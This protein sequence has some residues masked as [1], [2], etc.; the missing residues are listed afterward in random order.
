MQGPVGGARHLPPRPVMITVQVRLFAGLRTL[1]PG[2]GLGEVLPV[3]LAKGSTVQR[4]I[5]QLCL[6]EGE[7][8]L[9]FVNGIARGMGHVLADGDELGLFPP[10]GGG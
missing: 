6:P 5:R 10:V 1:K 3:R 8:K 4:L 2:L 7:V 9:I